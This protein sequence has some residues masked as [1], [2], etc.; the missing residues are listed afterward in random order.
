M[1]DILESTEALDEFKALMQDPAARQAFVTLKAEK[2]ESGTRRRYSHILKAVG[3]TPWAIRQSMLAVI[4]DILEFR[5][6][7]GHLTAEEIN[8][9]IGA[10]RQAPPTAT[11]VAVIP[12]HGVI[13]PRASLFSEMSGATSIEGLRAQF[14]EAMGTKDVGAVVFDVD[15]PGGMT[16][17]VPEMAAE[18]RAAR[19]KKP[20]VAVANTMMA[21]AA[22]WL[23]SQADEVVA[24]KSAL[25]GSI[26]VFTTHEDHSKAEEMKGVKTSLISAGKHKVDG[27]PSEP[28]NEDGR[29]TMQRLVDEFYG[30]FVGDVAKGRGVSVDAVRNG[31]GE[32]RLLGA[33]DGLSEGLIDR[34][35]SLED[36]IG[37]ML[38]ATRPAAMHSGGIVGGPAQTIVAPGVTVTPFDASDATFTSWGTGTNAETPTPDP[39]PEP[40]PMP[41]PASKPDEKI[42]DLQEQIAL[43]RHRP[44]PRDPLSK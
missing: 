13:M 20:M 44:A 12:I 25:V 11:G 18:I 6:S 29:A 33:K 27:A 28:L 38:Q 24:S 23:A 7:G 43:L 14:R 9:R 19:G 15:S 4:V 40:M 3:E 1:S 26:G 10:R 32:G 17:Q 31:F 16:D 41:E 37:T 22:Y 2:A 8:E 39:E 30:M 35:G 21:S 36:S 34:I 5:A 42:P